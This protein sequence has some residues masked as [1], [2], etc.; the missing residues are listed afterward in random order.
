M[1]ESDHPFI[2]IPKCSMGQSKGFEAITSSLSGSGTSALFDVHIATLRCQK[3]RKNGELYNLTS[4]AGT[5]KIVRTCQLS[6]F[7]SKP[8]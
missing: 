5:A 8:K 7:L 2:L 3:S 1:L 6:L 4:P